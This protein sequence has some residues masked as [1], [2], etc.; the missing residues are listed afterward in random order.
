MS[1]ATSASGRAEAKACPRSRASASA[2]LTPSWTLT[3]PEAWWMCAP[4]AARRSSSGPR[5]PRD[6]RE[7]HRVGHGLGIGRALRGQPARATAV[8]REGAQPYAADPER[9]GEHRHRSGGERRRPEGDP[10]GLRRRTQVGFRDR[11][12][13]GMGVRARTLTE[14]A[15]QFDDALGER[16]RPGERSGHR[17]VHEQQ[18]RSRDVESLAACDAH[19]GSGVRCIRSRDHARDV[20]RATQIPAPGHLACF[21]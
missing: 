8:E 16:V 15:L 2:T 7:P 19:G 10:P 13:R 12:P 11:H 14:C 17:A 1:D 5:L 9:V 4:W 3:M 18:A 21:P 20:G 6:D